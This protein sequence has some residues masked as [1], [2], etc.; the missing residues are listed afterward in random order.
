MSYNPSP[1]SV[2]QWIRDIAAAL[3]NNS[4]GG[5]VQYAEGATTA[6]A[7]GTAVLARY[8][9][10]PPSLTDAQM[11]ELQLDSGGNLKETLA[12]ALS[13]AIDSILTYPR[14]SNY[15]ELSASGL[16]LTGPGKLTGIFVA[17]ASGTPTIK[18]WDNTSGAT[19]VLIDQFTP[20]AG[21]MYNFPNPRVTTGIYITIGG[22][23]NCTAFFDPTTT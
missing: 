7:T 8:K 12:T 5:G 21:T 10:T 22:T 13:Q 2:Q 23:V 3:N 19:T 18:V 4:I 17:A 15:I 9:A 20:V 16:V 14:G 1:D 11:N 6:P